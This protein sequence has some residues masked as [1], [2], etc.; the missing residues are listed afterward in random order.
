M[1]R[2]NGDPRVVTAGEKSAGIIPLSAS[3]N[4]R[5]AHLTQARGAAP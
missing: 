2:E 1:A 4:S 5:L 3:E